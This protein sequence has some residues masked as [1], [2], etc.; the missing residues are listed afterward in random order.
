MKTMKVLFMML[1]ALAMTACS[2]SD[3]DNAMDI[4][5]K[6]IAAKWVVTEMNDGTGWTS[7]NI[8]DPTQTSWITISEDGFS[9]ISGS[10]YAKSAGAGKYT[11]S[12]CTVIIVSESEKRS[13]SITFSKLT[14][15]SASATISLYDNTSVEVKM[16]RDE[17]QPLYYKDAIVYLQGKWSTVFMRKAGNNEDYTEC[18][19]GYVCFVG[20]D[21]KV[22]LGDNAYKGKFYRYAIDSMGIEN[23]DNERFRIYPSDKQNE[24]RIIDMQNTLEYIFKRQ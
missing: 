1:L 23:N 6:S 11:F 10:L 5:A 20:N 17:S 14:R 12:G 15:E 18:Y 19:G 13:T 3:D 16:L 21:V 22:M 8:N 24:I 7:C 4:S 2:K 9:S